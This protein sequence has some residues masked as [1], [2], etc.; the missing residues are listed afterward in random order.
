MS[1]ID[2]SYFKKDEIVKIARL[3]IGKIG[4]LKDWKWEIDLEEADDEARMLGHVKFSGKSKA[5]KLSIWMFIKMPWITR[6]KL[7]YTKDG[8]KYICLAEKIEETAELKQL[9]GVLYTIAEK[10]NEQNKRSR[11]REQRADERAYDRELQKVAEKAIK[12]LEE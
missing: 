6:W 5:G 9:Y 12:A 1:D 10:V 3:L 7:G 8:K 2:I 4:S 11:R